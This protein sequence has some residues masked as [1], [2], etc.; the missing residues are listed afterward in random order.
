M[1]RLIGISMSGSS[2]WRPWLGSSPKL[3]AMLAQCERLIDSGDYHGVYLVG[4]CG[5]IPPTYC[6]HY[7]TGAPS[8]TNRAGYSE[9]PIHDVVAEFAERWETHA[10]I[11]IARDVEALDKM[12]Q[13][14]GQRWSLLPNLRLGLDYTGANVS[15][16]VRANV[17]ACGDVPV[18]LESRP[19]PGVEP[20]IPGLGF[21]T[22]A[23]RARECLAGGVSLDGD[24][25]VYN[26]GTD[27]N[28]WIE[29]EARG[30]EAIRGLTVVQ[31]IS[32]IES[33]TGGG[34]GR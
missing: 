22:M 31:P 18:R 12:E 34:G 25:I 6:G 20:S 28:R 2:G 3:G 16:M 23:S 13:D 21:Y 8:M 9:S 7:A 19:R 30:H 1:T 14:I 24:I 27:R 32:A 26:G 33:S 4:A 29:P 5:W 15:R 11:G 17:E 10:F